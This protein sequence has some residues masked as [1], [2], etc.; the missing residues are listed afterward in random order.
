MPRD[1]PGVRR[2]IDG[3]LIVRGESPLR[4]SGV[5]TATH[6]GRAN[7]EIDAGAMR[8]AQ[9]LRGDAFAA[10][11]DLRMFGAREIDNIGSAARDHLAS[12]RTFLAWVRTA[13]GVIGLGVI[14]GKFVESDGLVAEIIGLAFIGFGAL[15]LVYAVVRFHR[16][17]QIM[18]EGRYEVSYTGPTLVAAVSLIVAFGA[19]ALVVF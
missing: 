9:Q 1:D 18:E 6:G 4:G 10:D 2:A 8:G 3:D 19:V 17:S 5:G 11:Y 12:E 15:M 7:L 14:I 13:L 16:L